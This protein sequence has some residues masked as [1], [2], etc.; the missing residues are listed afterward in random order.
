MSL[1]NEI[2]KL[3]EAIEENTAVLQ[4]SQ[5][6]CASKCETEAAKAE[7]PAA[8]QVHKPAAAPTAP[9]APQA[10]AGSP[11]PTAPAAVPPAPTQPAAA[12]ANAPVPP[13]PA[14]PTASAAMT[15]EQVNTVL[16]AIA[17]EMKD[18]G[19]AI[20]GIL[21]NTFGVNNV[22]SL[23]AEQYPALVEAVQALGA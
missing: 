6:P 20:Y 8:K 19:A 2:K 4:G 14:A 18:G 10:V 23:P 7:V 11:A 22:S 15:A 16:Q 5:T 13:A 9:S 3:R 21:Q 12:P 1:E 17:G